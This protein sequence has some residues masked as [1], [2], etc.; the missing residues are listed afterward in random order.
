MHWQKISTVLWEHQNESSNSICRW[1]QQRLS[2]I[3]LELSLIGWESI[4]DSRINMTVDYRE[5]ECCVCVCVCARVR[6]VW[7]D[8]NEVYVLWKLN[9]KVWS[10][11]KYDQTMKDLASHVRVFRLYR[12]TVREWDKWL[13]LLGKGGLKNRRPGGVYLSTFRLIYLMK[14]RPI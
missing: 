2:R 13:C 1:N 5:A 4:S 8:Y 7:F 14:L 10:G 3:W 11:D 12:Y 6:T 9:Y